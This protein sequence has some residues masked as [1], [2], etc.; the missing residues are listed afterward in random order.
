MSPTTV[1]VIVAITTLMMI[2]MLVMFLRLM[3]KVPAGR[4]LIINKVSMEPMVTFS[5]GIVLPIVHSAEEM[6]VTTKVL[7]LERRG[8][9]GLHCRDHYSVDLELDFHIRVD[10][11]PDEVLRVAKNVGAERARDPEV[12]RELFLGKFQEAVAAVVSELDLEQLRRE[13]EQVRDRILKVIGLDLGGYV[14]L[15][16]AIASLGPTPIENLD[17]NDLLD[18]QAIRKLTE[19]TAREQVR[20]NEILRETEKLLAGLELSGQEALL[21]LKKKRAEIE[22]AIAALGDSQAAPETVPGVDQNLTHFRGT[23]K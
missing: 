21:E 22:A 5:G 8:R 12:L 4:A 7:R 9:D 3:R 6:D 11:E 20:T 1:L 18:A 15:D 19:L 16:L 17:P 13:R 23:A 2:G 10:H 14:L